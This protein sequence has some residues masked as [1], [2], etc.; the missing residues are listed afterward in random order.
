[1]ITPG[2]LK[3]GIDFDELVTYYLQHNNFL[4]IT[5]PE[6]LQMIHAVIEP[7]IKNSY[8]YNDDPFLQ[9]VPGRAQYIINSTMQ[10]RTLE[11]AGLAKRS[12]AKWLIGDSYEVGT[13]LYSSNGKKIEAKIY[14]NVSRMSHFMAKANDL[15]N[16]NH[17]KVFHDADY[18]NCYLVELETD[19]PNP[20]SHWQW[21]KRVNGL[22]QF[23]T[24]E[25]DSELFELTKEC[26]PKSIPLCGCFFDDSQNL[27]IYKNKKNI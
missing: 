6:A 4:K 9:T 10:E 25:T 20:E 17:D 27:I 1:M 13:D 15:A 23:C 22:Y 26:L 12:S 19:A 8:G 16:V 24:P 2:I 14:K 3:N 21:L 18:V 11:L 7:V 5:E